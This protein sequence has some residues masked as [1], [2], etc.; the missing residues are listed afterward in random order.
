MIIKNFLSAIVTGIICSLSMIPYLDNLIWIG[1]VPLLLIRTNSWFQAAISGYL[2][3]TI[4]SL[5]R[6]VTSSLYL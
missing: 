3:G 2:A 1:L 4:L 5:N 6:Q